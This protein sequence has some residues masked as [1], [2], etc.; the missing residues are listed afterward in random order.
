MT[1]V[2]NIQIAN[3]LEC[4]IYGISKSQIFVS[5]IFYGYP[6]PVRPGPLLTWE[7]CCAFGPGS[8]RPSSHH[9]LRRSSVSATGRPPRR[10]LPCPNCHNHWLISYTLLPFLPD[11]SAASASPCGN[12]ALLCWRSWCGMVGVELPRRK[13]G[14]K[15]MRPSTSA[16]RPTQRMGV[17]EGS[18]S[19]RP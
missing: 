3:I 12:L 8:P 6:I 15:G 11:S 16:A 9:P 1:Y 2:W 18:Y 10:G 14:I 5:G 7:P 13:R 17:G 19:A 4:H